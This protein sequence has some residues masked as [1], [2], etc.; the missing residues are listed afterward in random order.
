MCA[1]ISQ[2]RS[3]ETVAA[4]WLAL[5]IAFALPTLVRS[6]DLLPGPS[7]AFKMTLQAR[8]LLRK[9]EALASVNLGVS[10]REG[11]A[12]VWGTVPSKELARH[13]EERLRQVKG[14][15]QVRSTIRVELPADPVPTLGPQPAPPRER[16]LP[17]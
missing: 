17:R 12:T 6:A 2:H 9:D 14:V 4:R 3:I 11:I 10:V 8:Q 16:T 7:A 13:V 5:T 1:K 15:T